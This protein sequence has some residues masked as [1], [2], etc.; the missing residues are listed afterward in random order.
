[1]N[2]S[3]PFAVVVR[4]YVPSRCALDEAGLNNA[5]HGPAASLSI[6]LVGLIATLSQLDQTGSQVTTRQLA[7]CA[8]SGLTRMRL[9]AGPRFAS[10][11]SVDLSCWCVGTCGTGECL[12]TW[13]V[14]GSER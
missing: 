2:D 12:G 3:E 7:F 8:R 6:G 10:V 13:L 14:K 4:P 1:M 9:R 11:R 5:R